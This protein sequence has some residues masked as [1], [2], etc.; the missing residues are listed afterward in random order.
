MPQLTATPGRREE[1]ADRNQG[2]T[3]QYPRKPVLSSSREEVRAVPSY[4]CKCNQRIDFTSIPAETSYHLVAD[5][6][7]DVQEDVVTHNA[8]WTKSIQVPAVSRLRPA[9]GVLGRLPQRAD[10]VRERGCRHAAGVADG[11]DAN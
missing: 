6:D 3:Y 4:L 10:P 8:T 5:E 9:G 7:V 2:R 1:G 11:S